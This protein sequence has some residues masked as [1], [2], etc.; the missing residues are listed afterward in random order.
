MNRLR[1]TQRPSRSLTWSTLSS[2][3]PPMSTHGSSSS[4]RWIAVGSSS[5]VMFSAP[6][7][8]SGPGWLRVAVPDTRALASGHEGTQ[9]LDQ[10]VA[11]VAV[12]H[13]EMTAEHAV[14]A[15]LGQRPPFVERR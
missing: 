9:H 8:R 13:T 7:G 6:W 15:R 2:E 10:R 11:L 1:I 4:E 12:E 3:P 5:I 14:G